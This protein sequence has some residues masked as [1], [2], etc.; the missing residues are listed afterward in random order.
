MKLGLKLDCFKNNL[1][2]FSN[3]FLKVD[4]LLLVLLDEK[5]V[6]F[7]ESSMFG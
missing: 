2:F 3:L 7:V 5:V 4:F 1:L 6:V